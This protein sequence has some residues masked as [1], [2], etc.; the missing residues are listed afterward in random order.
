MQVARENITIV[1]NKPKYAGNVGAVARC[2]KNMGLDKICVVSGTHLS[3]EEMRKSATHVAAGLVDNIRHCKSLRETLVDFQYIVGTTARTGSTRGPVV[4]PRQMAERIVDISQNN[5]VALLFGSEDRGLTND[6]LRWCH[7]LVNIPTSGFKSLNLSHAAMIIC[8]EI[9]TAENNVAAFTPK[10]ATA[11]ELEGM[12]DQINELL[13][14]IGFMNPQ[15]PD[16]WL[17]HIRRFFSRTQLQA[18]E[19]KIIRG[20]CRQ[21][22]WHEANIGK[23]T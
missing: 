2:A 16:Y 17:K 10:L 11:A 5:R 22:A 7:L 21:L 13:Q 4:S 18:R 6:D 1:L 19:V 15:N 23:S 9:F 3:S 12:Y 8:Y 20:I 14:K